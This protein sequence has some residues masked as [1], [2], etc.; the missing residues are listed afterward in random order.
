M[1][2]IVVTVQDDVCAKNHRD[3]EAKLLIEKAKLY[4]NV[5]SGESYLAKEKSASQAVIDGLNS[6]L[7]SLQENKVTPAELEIL[8][9]LRQKAANEGKAYEEEIAA[10]KG[11]LEKVVEENESRAR[12]IKAIL[13]S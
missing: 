4:G 6:Q 2:V 8:R 7:R 1:K 13:G 5:E 9:V 12:Q 3:P 11:Q 10:L